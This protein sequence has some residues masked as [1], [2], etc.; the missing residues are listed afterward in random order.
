MRRLRYCI[1]NGCGIGVLLGPSGSGKT[2]LLKAL[3]MT[4]SHLQPFVTVIFPILSADEMLR[5][6]AADVTANGHTRP[7]EEMRTDELLQTIRQQLHMHC[8]CGNHPVICFDDAHLLS[9]N[10]IQSVVQPLVN[11]S[12]AFDD[13]QFSLLLSG[14]PVLLSHLK[15][16]A[17]V[18]DRIGVTAGLQGLTRKETADYVRSVIRAAGSDRPIFSPEALER[19]FDITGG[20]PRRINRMC[21]MA[22]LVGFAEQLPEISVSEVEAI[23]HEL[24][25]LAA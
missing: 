11:L 24:I 16:H 3:S 12:D 14:Q 7:I 20:I 10:V 13:L 18:S 5:I 22:L 8:Q 21:D 15:R 23:S 4:G 25:P 9:D 19:L 6:I 1:E 2:A 17:Q